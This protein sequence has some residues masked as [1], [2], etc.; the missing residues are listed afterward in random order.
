MRRQ[1]RSKRSTG[2]GKRLILVYVHLQKKKLTKHTAVHNHRE[3]KYPSRWIIWIEFLSSEIMYDLCK[4][5]L[6]IKDKPR[7]LTV[8]VVRWN[9]LLFLNTPKK[10]QHSDSK[11]FI[12]GSK[13]VSFNFCVEYTEE[14]VF[15]SH[16]K[17]VNCD[18]DSI[19][20]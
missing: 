18:L 3:L 4:L 14:S 1:Y 11:K 13:F 2:M 19:L 7:N 6:G 10:N 8:Q 17:N 9:T 12:R 15:F 5:K 16:T 20:N